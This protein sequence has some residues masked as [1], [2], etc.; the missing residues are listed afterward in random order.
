M[1]GEMEAD[2]CNDWKICENESRSR[3]VFPETTQVCQLGIKRTL[4][5]I[6]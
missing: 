3:S 1:A 2:Q 6:F 4:K 5:C